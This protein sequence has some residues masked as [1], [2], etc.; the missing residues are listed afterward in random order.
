MARPFADVLRDLRSGTLYDELTAQFGE[1]A[2]AVRDTRKAGKITITLSMKPNG[3]DSVFV[4]DKVTASI[5]EAAKG[6]TLFFVT[7]SGSVVRSDPRQENLPLRRVADT[8][9]G[10]VEVTRVPETVAGGK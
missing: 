5:P 10:A 1:L 7:S 4:T 2:V 6:D 3:D 9:P 8:T